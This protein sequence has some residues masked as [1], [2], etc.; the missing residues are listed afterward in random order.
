MILVLN[1]S[2]LYSTFGVDD[3]E[4]LDSAVNAMAPSMVEYYLSD[5]SDGNDDTY[6]NKKNIQHSINVGEYSIYL[7]YDDEIYLE[8]E[9]ASID[10]LETG[11]LW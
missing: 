1:K 4:A 6:L 9:E 2:L 3:F 5:L 8:V 11:T 10:E 7:D